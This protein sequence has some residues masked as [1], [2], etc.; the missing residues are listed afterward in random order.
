M[1]D[2]CSTHQ[3]KA[4]SLVYKKQKTVYVTG[5]YETVR[6]YVRSLLCF[7]VNRVQHTAQ[8]RLLPVR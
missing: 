6:V 5:S 8:E 1:A 3:Y 2:N 7:Y 4:D